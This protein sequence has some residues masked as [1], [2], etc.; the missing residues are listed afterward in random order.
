MRG[1]SVYTAAR[2]VSPG[3]APAATQTR[4]GNEVAPSQLNLRG[5]ASMLGRCIIAWLGRVREMPPITEPSRGA[6]TYMW[7]ATTTPAACGMFC[8][9][10]VGWPGNSFDR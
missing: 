8:T 1:D 3:A 2:D 6:R 9:T 10:T 5:S 4:P 7:L